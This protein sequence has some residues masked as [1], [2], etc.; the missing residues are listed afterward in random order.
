MNVLFLDTSY[1]IA[2]LRR[3]DALHERA[4]AWRRRITGRLLTTEYVVVEFLDA[5]AAA[6]VRRAAVETVTALRSSSAV[7]VVPATSAILTDAISVFAQ[8]AD[9]EWGLTDCASFVVMR[10]RGVHEALTGDRHFE[11]AGFRALLRTAPNQ[12]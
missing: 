6:P 12:A 2:L 4:V 8:H 1:L 9:K 10:A 3:S 7:E 11:Q 5:M